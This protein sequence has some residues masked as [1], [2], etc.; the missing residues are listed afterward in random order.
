MNAIKKQ[1]FLRDL[2]SVVGMKLSAF[3][4][5]TLAEKDPNHRGIEVCKN[6]LIH[7]KTFDVD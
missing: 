4:T 1:P 7:K 5:D 2:P 3:Y 6:S